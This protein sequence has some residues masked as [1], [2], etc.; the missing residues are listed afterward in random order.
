MC[1]A[2]LGP[3]G[4]Q[5]ALA[6]VVAGAAGVGLAEVAGHDRAVD[7]RDDLGQGDLLGRAG[8][9]VAAADAPLGAD[10]AGALQGQQ[11]LLEV[12]L[13]EAGA[14]GDVAH[15]GGDRLAR[16]A[17]P[18]T[19][20]PGS[21]SRLGSRPS[22]TS[23][24]PPGGDAAGR[25]AR[26]R[27]GE[28]PVTR[29]DEVAGAAS[30]VAA[31][32]NVPEPVLPDFGGPTSAGVADAVLAQVQGGPPRAERPDW[33]PADV[34]GARQVVLLV[35]D[36][37]GWEQ[38]Q[39]ERAALAPTLAAADSGP[40]TSVAP[41]TTAAALTSL[42]TGL[43]PAVHGVVGYRVAVRGRGHE[44]ARL[45]GGRRRR[46]PAG[47]GRGPSSLTRSFP[48]ARRPVRRSSRGPS[49]P[50]PDSPPPTWPTP[51]ST[52][53][54]TPSGLAVEVG[55]LLGQGEPF[56]YAYYD[57]IDRV[58][59]ARGLGA[60]YDAELRTADRLVGDICRP[61]AARGGAGGDGRPRSGRGRPGHRGARRGESW[62]GS[63]SSPARVD[64]AGSTSGPGRPTTWPTPPARRSATGLGADQGRG[65]RG[66]MAGRRARAGGGGSA[67][68]R[69]PRPLPAR[70]PSW[71]RPTP[72]SCAW[73]AATDP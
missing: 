14:L 37:L 29:P 73:S 55:R 4:E 42:T 65:H 40:I 21:R 24:L 13:G 46:P 66:G 56:V 59:H 48:R 58:A 68:R 41:S 51:H 61:P 1:L 52:A 45:D 39:A 36:G 28:P 49:T 72:A 6:L 15:R 5:D 35:L 69:R 9:H 60:H 44:R 25:P 8:E 71:T 43:P 12:G 64:S 34:V 33:L 22:R 47:A 7:R 53:G 38:L 57:G 50:P 27:G 32:A 62:T 31:V 26:G 63:S 10:E 18:G 30:R 20:A 16:R 3:D 54:Y 23:M 11:D 67:R 70:S 17:A 2:D 19:A